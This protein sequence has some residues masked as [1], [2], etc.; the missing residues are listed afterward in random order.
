M[1]DFQNDSAAKITPQNFQMDAGDDVLAAWGE[2]ASQSYKNAI[3]RTLF[4]MLDGTLFRT[5]NVVDDFK[6]PSE[7]FVVLKADLV[8]KLR[9][10]SLDSFGIVY[11]GTW[12]DAPGIEAARD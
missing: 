8:V 11:I 4:S 9:I 3:Y 10:N 6:V 12:D 7:F 1:E 2:T 5:H